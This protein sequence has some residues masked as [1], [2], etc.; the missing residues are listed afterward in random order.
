MRH[1]VHARLGHGPDQVGEA[2]GAGGDRGSRRHPRA[3]ELR[4]GPFELLADASEVG[5]L[6][7]AEFDL[8]E[9][10]EPMRE[11]DGEP[12][13]RRLAGASE[14]SRLLPV[15]QRERDDDCRCEGEEQP[16]EHALA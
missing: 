8:V 14:L 3:V 13:R 12:R 7:V 4:T 15:L 9:S 16:G 11:H 2:S 10:E 1:D 5:M 6:A